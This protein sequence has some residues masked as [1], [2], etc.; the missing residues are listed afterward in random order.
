A[1]LPVSGELCV[2]SDSG[3][4][5]DGGVA[6]VLLPSMLRLRDSVAARHGYPGRIRVGPG[7]ALCAP[8]ALAAGFLLAAGF[9]VTG[10]VNQCTVEA[11]TSE[12]VKDLLA[13]LDV[14]D[15]AYAPAGDLFELGARVQVARKGTL[16]AARANRLYQVY[17]Q[18][19]SLDDIDPA[20]RGT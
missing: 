13:A 2:E 5:T 10:S 18:H 8:E 19:Q 12:A 9:A 6:L 17:R 20:T 4:H 11:G 14:Q 1:S 15:T 3:G 7:G 16:F